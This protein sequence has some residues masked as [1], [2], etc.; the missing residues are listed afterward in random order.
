MLTLRYKSWPL[1]ALSGCLWDER[2]VTGKC[3]QAGTASNL[4]VTPV[5]PGRPCR[6]GSCPDGGR[7]LTGGQ[8]T[9]ETV[10]RAGH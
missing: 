7:A 4:T 2:W 10:L 9:Q 1:T 5:G 6:S 8:E 3:R